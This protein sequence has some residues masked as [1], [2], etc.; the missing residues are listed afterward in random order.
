LGASRSLNQQPGLWTLAALLGTPSLMLLD[1]SVSYALSS[2]ACN[3]AASTAALHGLSAACLVAGIVISI[4]ASRENRVARKAHQ[5]TLTKLAP[6]F[7]PTVATAV[8]SLSTLVIAM[9]WTAVF[10]LHPCLQ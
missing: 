9:M 5:Q 10:M 3:H 2:V 6:H 1:L 7:L 8:S 4:G